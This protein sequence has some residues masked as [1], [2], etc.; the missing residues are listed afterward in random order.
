VA[1]LPALQLDQFIAFR[2]K[3]FVADN[4]LISANGLD[5]GSLTTLVETYFNDLPAGKATATAGGYVGG[6]VRLKTSGPGYHLALAFPGAAFGKPGFD[7]HEVLAALLKAKLQRESAAATALNFGYKDAGLLVAYAPSSSAGN[8][9]KTASA[10]MG[11]FKSL[12]SVSDE[13]INRAKRAVALQRALA[14][15][16]AVCTRALE[17]AAL[18]GVEPKA[19]AEVREVNKEAVHKAAQALLQAKPSV[20]A[21]GPAMRSVKF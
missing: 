1:E 5:H 19:F 9:T 3:T 16:Q 17:R 12:T 6:E 8:S 10:L 11:A 15:E 18:A 14:N 7:S 2:Q 13:E 20:V 21:I 4:V